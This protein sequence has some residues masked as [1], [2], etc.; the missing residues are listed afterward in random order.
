MASGRSHQVVIRVDTRL[1]SAASIT[2]RSRLS[3]GG[4]V[5][6]TSIDVES[7]WLANDFEVS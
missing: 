7:H 2:N 3:E 1:S 6:L 4:R 5:R